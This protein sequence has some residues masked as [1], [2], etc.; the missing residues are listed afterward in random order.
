MGPRQERD[1]KGSD[2]GCT[3]SAGH[4][5]FHCHVFAEDLS[6]A[7]QE[8]AAASA[9]C[10]CHA[11]LD[12]ALFFEAE[13][14]ACV[15]G[16]VGAVLDADLVAADFA[17]VAYGAAE[18]PDCGVKEEQAFDG[19]LQ[20]VPEIVPATDVAEFMRDDGF[21]FLAREF[22][23]GADGKDYGGAPDAHG[24]WGD[25]VVGGSQDD[26]A[27]D[28]DLLAQ[29]LEGAFDFLRHHSLGVLA[30]EA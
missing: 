30:D 24:E 2:C 9:E 27:T 21:E 28:V 22:E 25:D 5:A 18:P 7:L 16:G 15:D 17:A 1:D 8:G 11:E 20:E 4:L 12:G 29:A 19:G 3:D 13:Q 6:D 26:L 10:H 14:G 23:D